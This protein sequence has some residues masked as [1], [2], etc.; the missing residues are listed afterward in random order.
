[1]ASGVSARVVGILALGNQVTTNSSACSTGAEAIALAAERIR[2]GDAKR[3]L[4]GGAEGASHYI[5]AG[6]D[7]MRVLC[8]SMND[9]PE[10]ASR[11]MSA[12]AVRLRGGGRRGHAAAREPRERA[13]SAA[14]RSAPSS[15]G[16]AVNCGGQRGG[17]SP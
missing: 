6:F 13:A 4:A 15:L 7:A 12:S 17:G 1:M 5:W 14:R 2:R 9:A 10:R 3:M 11:P 8:R 16:A